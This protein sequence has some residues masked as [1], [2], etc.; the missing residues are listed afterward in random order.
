MDGQSRAQAIGSVAAGHDSGAER[1][2]AQLNR[3]EP[4]QSPGPREPGGAKK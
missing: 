3:P 4:T 1:A 2:E